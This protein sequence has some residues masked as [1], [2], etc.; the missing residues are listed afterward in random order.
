M[1]RFCQK[2]ADKPANGN[3]CRHDKMRRSIS[4]KRATAPA[5]LNPALPPDVSDECS[6]W[7]PS[8]PCCGIKPISTANSARQC[9]TD[10]LLL[11]H[12]HVATKP[13]LSGELRR[14]GQEALKLLKC[15]ISFG[16][17][18]PRLSR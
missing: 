16:G 3:R 8:R 2:C 12:V 5:Q 7:L 4:P 18:Q 13:L 6:E 9:A 1:E 15:V 14:G 11:G 17:S 10:G